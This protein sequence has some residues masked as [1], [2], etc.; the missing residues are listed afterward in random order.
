MAIGA[1][2]GPAT[3]LRRVARLQ[4]CFMRTT[5][6]RSLFLAGALLLC[7]IAL[8]PLLAGHHNP[9]GLALPR[10]ELEKAEKSDSELNE[11]FRKGFMEAMTAPPEYKAEALEIM[12]REVDQFVDDLGLPAKNR[13]TRTNLLEVFVT[14]P[15]GRDAGIGFCTIRVG[16]YVFSAARSNKLSFIDPSYIPPDSYNRALERMKRG[17]TLSKALVNTNRA[18][19]LALKWLKAAHMDADALDR[20][21]K[22]EV[23]YWDLDDAFVPLYW[24]KWMKGERCAASVELFEPEERLMAMNI[25]DPR[26]N[27]RPS[28][29]PR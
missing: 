24:V 23:T 29:W 4:T 1:S 19:A 3:C 2:R 22:L 14:P 9:V 21:C 5:A 16:D 15:R 13:P 20:E 28:L 10:G 25:E 26:Y 18:H 11:A 12:M 17:V 27:L 8:W 7:A 6:A